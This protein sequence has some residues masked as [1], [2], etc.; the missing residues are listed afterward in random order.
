MC[1]SAC[2]ALLLK[3]ITNHSTFYNI[4]VHCPT[5]V[6]PLS[7]QTL[8]PCGKHSK[9]LHSCCTYCSNV[10]RYPQKIYVINTTV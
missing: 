6:K 2:V 10:A 8:S 4:T 7:G 3:A 5:E 9:M 1:P